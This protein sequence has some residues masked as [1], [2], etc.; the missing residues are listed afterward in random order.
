[1][2]KED[3]IISEDLEVQSGVVTRYKWKCTDGRGLLLEKPFLAM[4]I[5]GSEW[6]DAEHVC[7][8]VQW[9]KKNT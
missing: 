6:I 7:R 3:H 2:T 4:S 8:T 9:I 1:M 5:N